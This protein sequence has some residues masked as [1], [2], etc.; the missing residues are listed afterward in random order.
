MG[1]KI[2]AKNKKAGYNYSLAQTYEAGIQLRGT[3]IKSIRSGQCHITEAYVAIDPSMEVWLYNMYIAH[4]T[5]GNVNNHEEIRKRKLLLNKKEIIDI[6]NQVNA[7][8]YAI[9]PT[10]V[11][12]KKNLAKMEI[13]LGKGKK[14]HDKRQDKAKKDIER[15]LRQKNYD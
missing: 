12:L 15:K 9:V 7:G 2:I 13:A 5:Y 3:E 8:G 6:S 10:K 4:W 11:Y 14:L 1:I